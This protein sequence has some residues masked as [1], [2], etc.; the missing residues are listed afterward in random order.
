MANYLTYTRFYEEVEAEEW[1]RLL[2][3]NNIS[4]ELVKERNHLD[5][6]YIG[7]VPEPL[8]S[9]KI[10][11]HSFSRLNKVGWASARNLKSSRL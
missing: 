11:Q 1:I 8:Y 6:V 10:P 9:L 7:Q 4:Y 3:E 2:K 5:N